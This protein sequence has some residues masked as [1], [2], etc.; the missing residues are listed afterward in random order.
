[1]QYEWLIFIGIG[2]AVVIA[3]GVNAYYRR[4]RRQQLESVAQEWGFTYDPDGAVTANDGSLTQL[5]LFQKGRGGK[6]RNC[7]EGMLED[8]AVAIL[9]YRYTTGSGKNRRTTH[10]TVAAFHVPTATLPAFTLNSQ[11][12]IV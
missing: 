6:F 2:A 5:D 4:Q 7:L 12:S 1:M 9:D 10:Q 3:F 8:V 11:R